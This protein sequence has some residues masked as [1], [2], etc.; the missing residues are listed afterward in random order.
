MPHYWHDVTLMEALA[1]I[2]SLW[3]M[4]FFSLYSVFRKEGDAIIMGVLIE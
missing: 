2:L 4:I 1:L 3:S